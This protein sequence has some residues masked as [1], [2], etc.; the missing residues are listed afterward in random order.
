MA[1]PRNEELYNTIKQTAYRQLLSYGYTDTT[2]QSIA[3][4]C[5][6][7]RTA[8][9]NYY[10]SKPDLAL[11][12]F[13]DL[14]AVINN[15]ISEK[16]LH[17]EN[18]FDTMFCIGQSF[19]TFLLKDPES[20]KLLFDLTTSREITSEVLAFEYKWGIRFLATERTV[21]EEKFRDDVIVS[22]GGFYEL[23]YKYLKDGLQFDLPT[24]LGRVIRSIMHDHGYSYDDAK[25][26]VAA[27]VMTEA[28]TDLVLT[29]V[30]NTLAL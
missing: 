11:A 27:H 25:A 14:L 22:M 21:P 15:V 5:G 13:G 18:E 8:V 4:A 17:Q 1:R 12:F 6:V 19:F 28:E 24:H 30:S 7:T 3:S 29:E 20:R 16:A 9:Q 23:L 10:A 26:F 2:Y